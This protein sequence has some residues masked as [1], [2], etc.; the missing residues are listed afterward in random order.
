M[1][2]CKVWSSFSCC[3]IRDN[4]LRNLFDKKTRKA[5]YEKEKIKIYFQSVKKYWAENVK[6]MSNFDTFAMVKFLKIEMKS[7]K[8]DGLITILDDHIADNHRGQ[9]RY[10]RRCKGYR[11]NSSKS[12]LCRFI[13]NWC[14]KV[15]GNRQQPSPR[16][17]IFNNRL[18]IISSIGYLYYVA[19]CCISV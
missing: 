18:Y 17:Y 15:T 4:N 7:G 9:A 13:R 14:R 16:Q 6:I 8:C 5:K 2:F 11:C 3:G 19:Y 1:Q 12:I 10:F